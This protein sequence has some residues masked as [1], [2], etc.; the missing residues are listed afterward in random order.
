MASNVLSTSVTSENLS[1]HDMLAWVNESLHLTYTKIEQLCS[2]AQYCHL[3]AM[4]GCIHLRKVKFQAKLKHEY[5][6]NF[7]LLQAAF[8][9]TGMNKIIPAERLVKEKFQDNVEF[10]QWFK[11]FFDANYDGKEYN[12]LLARQGQ[13]LPPLSKAVITIVQKNPPLA[14]NGSSEADDQILKLNQ[15]FIDLKLTV[16]NMD[17]K[18]DLCLQKLCQIEMY[19][20]QARP[21]TEFATSESWTKSNSGIQQ[22]MSRPSTSVTLLAEISINMSCPGES[23]IL[24]QA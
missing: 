6:H 10:I 18:V 21:Q 5:I 15:Q 8:K 24:Q 23:G 19:Q 9:R 2:G 17:R 14:W 13:D 1:C 16:D 11:K 12:P 3:M 7:R 20:K 22:F 4:S